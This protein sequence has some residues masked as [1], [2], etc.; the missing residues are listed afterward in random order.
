[1]VYCNGAAD[2]GVRVLT[3][4]WSSP[5]F[6]CTRCVPCSTLSLPMSI[7]SN[8][9]QRIRSHFANVSVRARMSSGKGSKNIAETDGRS[10]VC[11]ACGA[12][13]HWRKMRTTHAA[14]E[15]SAAD[16]QDIGTVREK[17]LVQRGDDVL[18]R[19]HTCV[20][21]VAKEMGVTLGDAMKSIKGER[22]QNII[23]RAQAHSYAPHAC[24]ARVRV[25][26]HRRGA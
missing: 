12:R 5:C 7:F 23:E 22:T 11:I 17:H 16:M 24:S 18:A 25:S 26:W 19:V 4:S 1:M 6:P 20:N 3:C 10:R 2:R 15:Y 9:P 14:T 21:C 13:D 8:F